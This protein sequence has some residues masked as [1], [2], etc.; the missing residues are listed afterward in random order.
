MQA[1]TLAEQLD[2]VVGQRG[3]YHPGARHVGRRQRRGRVVE[4]DGLQ[5]G[6]RRIVPQE[7][8]AAGSAWG[9]LATGSCW[10]RSTGPPL[11]IS[12]ALVAAIICG[13]PLMRIWRSPQPPYFVTTSGN[14]P[15]WRTCRPRGGCTSG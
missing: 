9:Q 13:P 4:R 2:S 7:L 6:H 14:R 10:M 5:V 1:P 3:T 15:V 11:A 12:A 8:V